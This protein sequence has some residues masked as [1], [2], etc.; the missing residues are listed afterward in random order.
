MYNPIRTGGL[1]EGIKKTKK[2]ERI[3]S[4]S[5]YKENKVK[6]S[7]YHAGIVVKISFS[8]KIIRKSKENIK[9]TSTWIHLY[10][11]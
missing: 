5:W 10:V 1:A 11:R 9:K 4:P 7:K 6:A 3:G 8:K 2:E